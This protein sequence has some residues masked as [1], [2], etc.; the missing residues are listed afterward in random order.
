MLK[1]R[2]TLVTW[3]RRATKSYSNDY[4]MSSLRATT[5]R[6]QRICQIKQNKQLITIFSRPSHNAYLYDNTRRIHTS[7][8]EALH[9]IEGNYQP[10]S[11]SPSSRCMAPQKGCPNKPHEEHTR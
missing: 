3:H 7:H 1:R 2:K 9:P 11:D 8:E 5:I 10:I 4:L 6:N